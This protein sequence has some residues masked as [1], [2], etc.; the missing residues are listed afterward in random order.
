MKKVTQLFYDETNPNSSV[1][2]TILTVLAVINDAFDQFA[3]I[4][5]IS[6]RTISYVAGGFLVI[7]FF[8]NQLKS[9]GIIKGEKS[10][11]GKIFTFIK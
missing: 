5:G 3:S 6:D 2:A 9:K 7:T 11:V 1:F 10:F 4:F 8:Y